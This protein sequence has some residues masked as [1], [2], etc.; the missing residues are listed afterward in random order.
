VGSL[1]LAQAEKV[2]DLRWVEAM[3]RPGHSSIQNLC[4]KLQDRTAVKQS[5]CF[6]VLRV[7]DLRGDCLNARKPARGP[8]LGTKT[9]DQPT[10]L[11]C[12]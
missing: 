11:V 5:A 8:G 1:A 3:A 6:P 12:F 10:I 7:P 4:K 2:G 9:H